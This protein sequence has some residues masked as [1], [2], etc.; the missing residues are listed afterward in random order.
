MEFTIE[1][2][3]YEM[4]PGE[5]LT[6]ER[7]QWHK[8]QTLHGAIVEEVSTQAVVGDSYYEDPRIAIQSVANRKTRNFT[9]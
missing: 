7:G 3:K 8:F 2:Q 1:G 9:I 5:L 6:V 4:K